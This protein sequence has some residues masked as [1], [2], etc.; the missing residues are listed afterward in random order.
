MTLTRIKYFG[1]MSM[2]GLP[3]IITVDPTGAIA[4]I[5]RSAIELL[6]LTVIQI[7]VPGSGDALE[8]LP[9]ARLVISAVELDDHM[10][11]YEFAL[12]AKQVAPETS[13]VVLG[14]VDDPD[15]MDEETAQD[16]PFVY[17]CRPLEVHTFLKVMVAGME[18]HDAMLAAMTAP[19]PASSNG[20]SMDLGTVPG[21]DVN[22]AQSIVDALLTDLGAMAIILA[23]RT[24]ETLLER[25]AVGYIDR[26]QL[27]SALMPIMETNINVKDLVGGQASTV[28][29]YDGDDYDVFVLS[30][31]LHHFM[32]VM[33]DGQMGA[34]QH[35]LVNRFGRRAVEDLIAL[36]GANA[37]LIQQTAKPQSRPKPRRQ[38]RRQAREVE[39]EEPIQRT[40]AFENE[41][42]QPEPVVPQL[43]PVEDLDLDRLFGE[44]IAVDDDMFDPDK[45]EEQVSQQKT[46]QSKALDWDQAMQLGII[47]DN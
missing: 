14:D 45:L 40:Q 4:R 3:R 39:V 30:V 24:G 46:G 38:E 18:S 29:F 32:C 17:M 43:D 35:G 47:P 31:G 12:R 44:D 10:K 21:L 28:Q 42:K 9:K 11:G 20:A 22:A 27:T 15:E 16:S 36:L 26:E 13:V 5:V 6:D 37:F 1:E 19:A 41:K 25:G 23:T 34:R 8:E 2:S 33:F 7:D